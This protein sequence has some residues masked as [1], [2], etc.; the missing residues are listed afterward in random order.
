MKQHN[1]SNGR[2]YEPREGIFYPSATTILSVMPMSKWFKEY[3]Q[4]HTKEE[5][6]KL[7]KKAGLQGSKIHHTID[8]ILRGDVIKQTGFTEEQLFKT[9]LI[10]DNNHGNKELLD[11]LKK[12]FTE[13]EDRMMRGFYNW[14]ELYKPKTLNSELQIFSDKFK[15]AGTLDW[16]GEISIDKKITKGKRKGD[17]IKEKVICIID[18]KSGKNI[19]ES[20][21]MQISSYLHAYNEMFK[22]DKKIKKPKRAFILQLGINKCGYKFQ[23]I[24]D[25][26]N[27]FKSFKHYHETW[28]M[29]NQ[30]A[31]PSEEYKFLSEYKINAV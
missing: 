31:K 4:N 2:F 10:T 5:A 19:Y 14:H 20:Y 22:S 15:Y 24:K 6:D 23:E 7:L 12:P 25:V 13:K 1:A 16:V 29:N 21:N 11:Y 3:L 9:S 17:I 30:D 26:K 28:K 27:S 18:W 8:F